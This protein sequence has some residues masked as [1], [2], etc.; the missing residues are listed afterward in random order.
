MNGIR[1]HFATI[2]MFT[3]LVPALMACESFITPV[4]R[5]P[6]TRPTSTL[7]PLS[8]N[9]QETE[10]AAAQATLA[11]GQSQISEINRQATLV[12]L[13]MAQAAATQ[14]FIARQTQTV[15]D[16]TATVQ[17]Q[18]ATAAAQNQGATATAQS[19]D[20]TAVAQNQGAT[21]TAQSQDA[22]AVTQNQDA[23]ATAQSR[24]ATATDSA[25]IRNV[26]QT[27][28]AQV[29]LDVQGTHTALTNATQAAYSLTATPWAA[30]QADIV[31]T[32][33]DTQ[34]RSW[35]GEFVTTPLRIILAIMLVIGLIVGGVMV[36]R[37]LMPVLELY[38][39][40]IWRDNSNPLLLVGRKIAD[41]NTPHHRFTH[42]VLRQTNL[43]PAP[44][45]ETPQVEIIEPFESPVALWIEETEQKLRTDGRIQL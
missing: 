19:Q 36:Y 28:Q 11:S 7:S 13:N 2:L 38:A 12:S 6:V 17:S 9:I 20:A 14:R 26:T 22:T 39:R 43:A 40:T 35:W 4:P 8:G 29:V 32:R 27:V 34:R 5:T 41:P 18:D 25:Y 15:L 33:N 10:Y 45:Y 42:W 30:I 44:I 3:I 23:T 31:R 21:A 16:A 37:R 24:D 1:R